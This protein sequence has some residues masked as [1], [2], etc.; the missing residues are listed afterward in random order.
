MLNATRSF[1][2]DFPDDR[3]LHPNDDVDRGRDPDRLE[4]ERDAERLHREREER[5]RAEVAHLE[6]ELMERERMELELLERMEREAAA[7]SATQ[8]VRSSA[9]S[10]R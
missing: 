3:H 9:L 10:P 4:R 7:A 2:G 5:H 1:L 8:A 6:R